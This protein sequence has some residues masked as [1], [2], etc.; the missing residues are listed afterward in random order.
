MF[1]RRLLADVGGDT[2]TIPTGS[3]TIPSGAGSVT[4]PQGVNVVLV[5]QYWDLNDT[6]T[7]SA[8]V[9]VTAGK[10]YKLQS[11]WSEY[12]E[13]EGEIYE[14]DN[15]SNWKFWLYAEYGTID[16]ETEYRQ[17]PLKISWSPT[18]NEKSPH[19]TDY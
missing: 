13:G 2:K 3:I 16:V 17:I 6:S 8:L 7:E 15:T 18:I 14:V 1:N 9:G 5:E 10:T 12:N 19:R 11:L 4:I